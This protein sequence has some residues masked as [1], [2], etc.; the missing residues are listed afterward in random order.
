MTFASQYSCRM[1]R[2]KKTRA[3]GIPRID[4]SLLPLDRSKLS[5]FIV[6]ACEEFGFFTV[7][8][9]GIPNHIIARMEGEGVE[10]FA[11]PASEKQRAGP[12]TPF[13][14]GCKNIGFNGD[15]GELEYILMEANPASVRQRSNTVSDHPKQF[16]CAVN[17][18]IEAV[19]KL[20]CEILELAAEGLWVPDKSVFSKVIQDV[21]SDS[22][23]R[24]NH[25]PPSTTT[26]TTTSTSPFSNSKSPNSPPPRVG[27]GE[28]SDPQI[29]TILRSNDVPGLQI[30]CTPAKDDDDDD[31]DEDEGLWISVPPDPS[32]FCVFVGDAFQ[33]LTNGRF[34][35]VRHRVL[36]NSAKPRMSTI[37]FGAP[38]L[39]ACISPLPHLVSRHSPILYRPFTWGEF[40]KAVYSTRLADHRLDLF[41]CH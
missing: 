33:A 20:A 24:I 17:E 40:K 19:R 37:F 26:T 38:P 34:R 32:Q 29:L 36:A 4:L 16:S 25:Y 30:C 27:F 21:N 8:N 28:H 22:C 6:E 11:K 35:S 3:L 12:P 5:K 41:K 13:G 39:N 2:R 14:Y 9:H 31:D 7:A 23:F 15:K 10:F 18:Y 1:M